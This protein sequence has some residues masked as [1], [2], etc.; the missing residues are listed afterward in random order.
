MTDA[1]RNMPVPG[2]IF[3]IEDEP[4]DA[5][6]LTDW[7][8]DGH[9]VR[10][11][12]EGQ[13]AI[14]KMRDG[15]PE[16]VFLDY[17]LPH[18]DGVTVMKRII[19]LSPATTVVFVSGHA[20]YVDR[21]K[22]WA[23]GA[24]FV[25]DKSGREHEVK[26]IVQDVM[27]RSAERVRLVRQ[28]WIDGDSECIRALRSAIGL[29]ARLGSD[30]FISGETGVG[31]E[32]VARLVALRSRK[33]DHFVVVNCAT[34]EE[35]VIDS[36]LFGSRKGSFTGV[37]NRI[38]L[39]RTAEGGCI[40]LDE[41][42]AIP[43][44]LQTKFN[45]ALRERK[46]RPVGSDKDVPLKDVRVISATSQDLQARVAQGSFLPDL[47]DRL[48][49]DHQICVPPLRARG[50]DISPLAAHFFEQRCVETYKLGLKMEDGW[51]EVISSYDWP[52]NVSQLRTV[53]RFAV[54]RTDGDTLSL[55]VLSDC[56]RSTQTRGP[57][58]VTTP[59]EDLADAEGSL[60]GHSKPQVLRALVR[61]SNKSLVAKELGV[62]RRGLQKWV[63]R[64]G[65][66]ADDEDSDE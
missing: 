46:I 15:N 22:M 26:A 16:L 13:P 44:N 41:V 2:L 56:I 55:R 1:D 37:E 60:S 65:L 54:D 5:R 14:D 30:V 45:R 21:E 49:R 24:H 53:V 31:K 52:R 48:I 8:G 59:V 20:T 36:E 66:S 43:M 27:V 64:E 40:F 18:E 28:Y 51:Q 19:E 11:F 25:L 4:G 57:M 32:H 9:D 10:P 61:H 39:F 34:L 3:V 62:S 35:G 38:G 23:H 29:A 58:S 7:I 12:A 17:E 63:K 50:G 47:F 6:R 33:W 42:G